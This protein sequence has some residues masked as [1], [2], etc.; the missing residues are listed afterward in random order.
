[1]RPEPE[2]STS[3][4]LVQNVSLT[5]CS[6]GTTKKLPFRVDSTVK[7]KNNNS[8]TRQYRYNYYSNVPHNIPLLSGV[9]F[10]PSRSIKSKWQIWIVPLLHYV[11]GM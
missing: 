11:I 2:A 9:A 7:L 4:K 10:E 6:S 1:M 8:Y 5:G 3:P